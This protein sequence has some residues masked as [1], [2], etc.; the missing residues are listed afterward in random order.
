MKIG[1][2]TILVDNID[3]A[4]DFYINKLGFIKRLDTI[5]WIGLRYVTVSPKDQTDV[6]LALVLADTEK[7]EQA[8]GGQT[9]DHIVMAIET[10]DFQRDYNALKAKGVNF[11]M[12]PEE[13]TW[14]TEAVF[15]DL[16]GNLY[17]LIQPHNPPSS[18]PA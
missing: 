14:G 13:Q 17:D 7:K 10:D 2:I 15:E 5:I 18:Q 3:D 6:Q 9:G 1:H 12:H 4:L 11:L 8:V 16:Y